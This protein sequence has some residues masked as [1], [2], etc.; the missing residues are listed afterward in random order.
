MKL[1]PLISTTLAVAEAGKSNNG[2]RTRTQQ[3]SVASRESGKT[4][5]TLRLEYEKSE[6]VNKDNAV[7]K[8]QHVQVFQPGSNCLPCLFTMAITDIAVEPGTLPNNAT[9]A[10]LFTAAL[11]LDYNG[12]AGT[13]DSMINIQGSCLVDMNT[14]VGG[15]GKYK[16][17]IGTQKFESGSYDDSIAVVLDYCAD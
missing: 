3:V 13:Y 17:A 11:N 7:G 8:T 14:V 4:C 15:T 5:G 9:N 6:L 16:N 10:C 1:M 2:L 12:F